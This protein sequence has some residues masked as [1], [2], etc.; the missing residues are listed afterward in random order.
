MRYW[1]YCALPG[2][3]TASA[4]ASAP[5]WSRRRSCTWKR[6]RALRATAGLFA[7][8]RAEG[9]VLPLSR[10]I[11]GAAPAEPEPADDDEGHG[12]RRDAQR[13]Q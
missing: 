2:V 8:N 13:D 9:R 3:D 1:R 10:T 6:T 11:D 4:S 7:A 5:A 12:Q